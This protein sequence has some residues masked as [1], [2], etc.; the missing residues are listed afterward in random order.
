MHVHAGGYDA[1][2]LGGEAVERQGLLEGHAE[3]VFRLA[4]RDLVVG[5]RVDVGVHAEGDARVTPARLRHRA[6]CA[7]LWLGLHVEGEDAGVEREGHLLLGLADA[8]E[9]DALGR[10][11]HGKGAAKLALGDDIHAGAELGERRQHAEI[12]VGLNRVTDER[13]GVRGKGLGEH[14][15]MTLESRGRIAIE[16]GADGGREIAQVDLLGVKHV[17]VRHAA[18]VGEMVHGKLVGLFDQTVEDRQM[19]GRGLLHIR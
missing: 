19:P 8:G 6:Q 1:R 13:V 11:V 3:L 18:P 15:V 2:Q 14:P 7:K 10:H 12:R 16:R 4:G 5:L 17:C 9:G